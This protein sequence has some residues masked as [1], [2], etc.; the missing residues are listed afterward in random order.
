MND[1][2]RVLIGM[3][4]VYAPERGQIVT[5][6]FIMCAECQSAVYH[7]GGPRSTTL[8]LACARN[9]LGEKS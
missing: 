4:P 8:C 9:L 6:A 7:V 3:V 1:E 2:Q 5:Q